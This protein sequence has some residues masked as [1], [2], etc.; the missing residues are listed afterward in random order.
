MT[1]H[2]A[3]TATAKKDLKELDKHTTSFL[4]GWIRKN[5][6]GCEDPRRHGKAL[7]ANHAGE[8]RYRIGDYRVIVRIEDERIVILIITIRHRREVYR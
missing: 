1:Y 4:L 8:W 2:V 3:F 7:T 5:L 6:E